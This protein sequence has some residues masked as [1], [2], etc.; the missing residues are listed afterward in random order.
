MSIQVKDIHNALKKA[1]SKAGSQS[2]LAL[3]TGIDQKNISRWISLQVDKISGHQWDKLYPCI[4]EFLPEG[5]NNFLSKKIDGLTQE[6]FEI[7]NELDFDD[8]LDALK[9]MSRLRQE[10]KSV[11]KSS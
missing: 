1:V 11:S 3:R 8:R 2:A 9:F 6:M 4:A 5:Y 7:W 10:K